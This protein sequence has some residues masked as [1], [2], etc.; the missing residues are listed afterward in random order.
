LRYGGAI[1]VV[2]DAM[3]DV[4]FKDIIPPLASSP[5]ARTEKWCN[6]YREKDTNHMKPMMMASNP[7]KPPTEPP[8]IA[9]M[10]VDL[11]P[12]PSLLRS[13]EEG[14]EVGVVVT[15]ETMT[16]GLPLGRV[17]VVDVVPTL[18]VPPREHVEKRVERGA[19]LVVV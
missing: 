14:E 10:L 8:T 12:L 19:V 7:K 16:V 17:V 13:P 11:L 2:A 5:A 15:V 1:V 4:F 6:S 3:S 18:G 9:P